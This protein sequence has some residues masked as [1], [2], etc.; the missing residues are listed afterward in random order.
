MKKICYGIV[1]FVFFIG[2]FSL[3]LMLGVD[4]HKGMEYSVVKDMEEFNTLFFDDTAEFVVLDL[5]KAEDFEASHLK[6]SINIPYEEETFLQQFKQNEVG[7]VP[8]Y[9]LCYSGNMS[10][11]A[12]HQMAAEGIND[13]HYISFGYDDYLDFLVPDNSASSIE[14]SYQ[15]T[16]PE[17]Y[18]E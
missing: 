3:C 17:L 16:F 5:R 13:V 1:L 14:L 15:D 4:R 12:F 8:I 9:L 6:N 10:A 18:F 7:N 11:K 2:G